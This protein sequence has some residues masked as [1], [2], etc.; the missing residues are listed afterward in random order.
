MKG[1]ILKAL[2]AR[3][4]RALRPKLVGEGTFRFWSHRV[5]LEQFVRGAAAS[6]PTG[7]R[8]LDA[9]AGECM[10]RPLF[11]HAD[12]ESADFAQNDHKRYGEITYVCDLRTIPVEDSRYNM[13]LCTQ[14]LEHVPDPGAVLN[15]L[16]RVLKPG[17]RLWLS[18]PLYYPEHDAPF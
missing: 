15:E 13:V 4:R 18:A 16:Y 5:Y 2:R 9:G 7:A 1:G 8:V 17:G 14:V 10:Y 3:M 6:I 12:Y 11:A